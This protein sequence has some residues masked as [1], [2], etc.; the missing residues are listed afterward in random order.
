MNPEA[1]SLGAAWCVHLS[2]ERIDLLGTSDAREQSVHVRMHESHDI[3]FAGV[4]AAKKDCGVVAERDPLR[5]A[6]EAAIT[7]Q[8][9]AGECGHSEEPMGTE[10][11]GRWSTRPIIL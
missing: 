6:R 4:V 2:I 1:G 7:G 8:T 10:G 3:G 11:C 9:E 5:L